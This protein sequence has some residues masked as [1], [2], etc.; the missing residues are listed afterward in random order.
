MKRPIHTNPSDESSR[1]IERMSKELGLKKGE[2]IDWLVQQQ[3]KHESEL[4][5]S[6]LKE[7]TNQV[8]TDYYKRELT[9]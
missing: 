9:V 8:L 2:T 6:I 7:V 5:G 4:E 1:Y 3:K